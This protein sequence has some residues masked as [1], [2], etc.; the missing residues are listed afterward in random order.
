MRLTY[1]LRPK[2]IEGKIAAKHIFD[3][4]DRL[5]VSEA[6]RKELIEVITRVAGLGCL[7]DRD[8][9]TCKKGDMCCICQ[10]KAAI[11]KQS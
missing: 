2:V 4:C 10:A 1:E 5:D 8:M 9:A 6:S 3:L 11:E 7:R